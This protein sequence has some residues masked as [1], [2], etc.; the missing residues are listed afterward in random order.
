MILEVVNMKVAV[1][2]ITI[3][4]INTILMVNDIML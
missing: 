1:V 2:Y 3:A 4:V